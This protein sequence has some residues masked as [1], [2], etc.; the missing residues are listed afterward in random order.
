MK[1]RTIVFI[2]FLSRLLFFLAGVR[3]DIRPMHWFWQ[4]IDPFLLKTRLG[5][6]LFYLH[7]QPPGFNLLVGLGLKLFPRNYYLV[8]NSL[9]ILIG[10]AI[11][12]SFYYLLKQLEISDR[13]SLI[14]VIIFTI[15]PATILTENLFFYDYPVILLLILSALF[16]LKFCQKRRLAD[17]FV[18][19]FLLS[20][21]VLTRSMFHLFWFLLI[22]VW[23]IVRYQKDKNKIMTAAIVPLFLIFFLYIKNFVVVGQF[24]ANS[25]MGMGFAKLV[26][27]AYSKDKIKKLVSEGKISPLCLVDPFSPLEKYP[28]QFRKSKRTGIPLLDQ[29]KKST[30]YINFNQLNYIRISNQYFKDSLVLIASNP[31]GYLRKLVDVYANYSYPASDI[32][33]FK[34]NAKPIKF[35][36]GLYNLA[37]Y[38]GGLF[39]AFGF[40]LFIYFSLK[41]LWQN[42]AKSPKGIVFLFMF[43]VVMYVFIIG[44]LFEVDENHRYRFATEPFILTMIG[45]MMEKIKTFGMRKKSWWR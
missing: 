34:K 2:F 33:L 19:F 20:F 23:L 13:L 28:S 32:H 14:F 35:Y 38:G 7:G 30:G 5:E 24:S 43:F 18:F 27:R 45:M 29:A 41:H 42:K 36:E 25:W 8:F 39:I 40:P 26:L 1:T 12:V 44:N 17:A 3:F 4:F 10:L 22:L 37:I 21:L 16:L 31:N 15:N 11:T 6:S 9:F